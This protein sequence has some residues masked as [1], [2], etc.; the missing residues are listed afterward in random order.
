[1]L[2]VDR[3]FM[4]RKFNGT[5]CEVNQ[6]HERRWSN[7]DRVVPDALTRQRQSRTDYG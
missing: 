7:F 5:Q 1:M 6:Q 3:E 4:G 2:G